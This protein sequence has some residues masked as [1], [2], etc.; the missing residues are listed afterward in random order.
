MLSKRWRLFLIA[1]FVCGL[2][3]RLLWPADMEWKEDEY[4]NYI[5]PH[6]I[7]TGARSWPWT[8]MNSGVYI[9]NPGMSI[10]TFTVAAK[11]AQFFGATGPIGLTLVVRLI[12]LLGCALVLPLSLIA[13]GR[14]SGRASNRQSGAREPWLWAF[15]F[16]MVN[17]FLIY[18][19]R[20]LWPQTFLP[21]FCCLTLLGW[22]RRERKAGAF[23][24]GL[25]GALIGQVHMAGFF[26]AAALVLGALAFERRK[27]R[28]R[29]WFLG[30]CLGALPLLPWLSYLI[31]HPTGQPLSA[32][33]SELYQFKFWVFWVTDAL[34]LHLGN[35]LGLLLGGSIY[36]Q[37]SHFA[38]YPIIGGYATWICGIAHLI[39]LVS[40][41]AILGRAGI[42]AL[43][44]SHT[45]LQADLAEKSTFWGFGALLTFTMVNIRRY[46]LAAAF[47]FE[48]LWLARLSLGGYSRKQ[49]RTLLLALWFA[50]LV[51]S[52]SFVGYIHAHEG[53]TEG[54]FG[55]SYR[56]QQKRHLHDF[57]ESWPDLKL[58]SPNH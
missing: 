26:S 44:K 38:R 18:Y 22:Y 17:P 25:I 3:L 50:Q 32:G 54:D 42:L 46:Y 55:E 4:Y 5:V 16:S 39:A 20:K 19:H 12:A 45:G 57:G 24:W 56:V 43:K 6:L 48:A 33:Y 9:A 53:S 8:G 28:W 14:A 58:L 29:F 30:S 47:P 2:L 21:L 40:G 52:A 41:L 15:A 51:I 31:A 49:G 1:A 35:P 34:G 11:I 7:A 13:S 10:W 36:T 37:I 27:T 23:F